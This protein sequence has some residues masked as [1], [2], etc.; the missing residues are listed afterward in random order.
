MKD[1]QY[2]QRIINCSK[3]PDPSHR[4]F[5]NLEVLHGLYKLYTTFV[6]YTVKE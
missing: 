1:K 4:E 3:A 6:S 2:E 5:H